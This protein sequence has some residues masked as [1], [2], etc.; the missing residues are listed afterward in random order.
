[1]PKTIQGVHKRAKRE[2]WSCRRKV[3][4]QG[5][6]VEYFFPLDDGLDYAMEDG[7]IYQM[8]SV[9]EEMELQ[10]VWLGV[11]RR[12]SSRERT[13][14]ISHIIKYG[15]IK[16]S[17]FELSCRL[18]KIVSKIRLLPAEEQEAILTI[19]ESNL[20]AYFPAVAIRSSD[21]PK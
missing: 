3:G 20:T 13:V 16:L 2:C 19:V 10:E 8:P 18:E 15:V 5:P 7:P 6:A 14:L 11:F 1:M 17:Q 9:A 12:L 4:T 21:S